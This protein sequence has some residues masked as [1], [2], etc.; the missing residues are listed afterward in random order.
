MEKKPEW[1]FKAMSEADFRRIMYAY[2]RYITQ[3]RSK[4]RMTGC[5]T[6][7]EWLEVFCSG[8]NEWR[9]L[10]PR[11]RRALEFVGFGSRPGLFMLTHDGQQMKKC[12]NE[13][14]AFLEREKRDLEEYKR[15]QEKFGG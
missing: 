8:T 3:V 7:E 2:N 11:W 14:D 1:E 15:L 4:F 10:P 12:L 6:P 5:D 9:R 13:I